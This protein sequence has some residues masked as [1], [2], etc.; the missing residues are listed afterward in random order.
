MGGQSGRQR[1]NILYRSQYPD[2]ALESARGRRHRLIGERHGD[3]VLNQV[4]FWFLLPL[5]ARAP[6][7]PAFAGGGIFVGALITA[8][9]NS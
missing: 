3:M 7:F 6:R 4:K 8:A 1:E 2:N 9:N 5:P